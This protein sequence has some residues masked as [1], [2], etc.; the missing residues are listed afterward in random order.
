MRYTLFF[1][2]WYQYCN[3]D[4]SR[5]VTYLRTQYSNHRISVLSFKSSFKIMYSPIIICDISTIIY[6]FH[7]P[8][9][10]KTFNVE[11][12]CWSIYSGYILADSHVI[13]WNWRFSWDKLPNRI[14]KTWLIKI[15]STRNS[16]NILVSFMT[17]NYIIFGI[18]ISNAKSISSVFSMEE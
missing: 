6:G 1:L 13:I 15:R 5:Y 10:Y 14:V 17:S 12:R 4:L 16:L 7:V 8:H 3:N 9:I 18:I 11:S 2:K